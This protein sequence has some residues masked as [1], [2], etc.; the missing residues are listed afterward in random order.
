M[1]PTRSTPKQKPSPPMSARI[2]RR[3]RSPSGKLPSGRPNSQERLPEKKLHPGRQSI[4]RI[5]GGGRKTW[6]WAIVNVSKDYPYL[7]T[8]DEV[9]QNG[10]WSSSK[11]HVMRKTT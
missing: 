4:A 7:D 6:K 11:R 1:T 10:C 3:A 5:S 8:M 2:R 9:L